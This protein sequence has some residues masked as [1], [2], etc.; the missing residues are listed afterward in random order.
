MSDII[1]HLENTRNLSFLDPAAT[2]ILAHSHYAVRIIVASCQAGI[3]VE[4]LRKGVD[5]T[6]HYLH[7]LHRLRHLLL[8]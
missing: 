2:P 4:F 1:E 8:R 6:S 3:A 5:S 7:A